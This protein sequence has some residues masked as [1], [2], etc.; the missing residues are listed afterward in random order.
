MRLIQFL[1]DEARTPLVISGPTG[2]H[3][4]VYKAINTMIPKFTLQTRRRARKRSRNYHPG[5]YTIDEKH[6]QVFLS[7]D[8]HIKAEDMLIEAGALTEG[9]SLYDASN[10]I[11]LA[12]S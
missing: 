6:K 7:D 11:L 9:L 3:G 2:D 1:I 8:G 4:Q 12:A 10:I 5:D